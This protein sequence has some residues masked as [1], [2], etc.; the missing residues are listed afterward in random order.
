MS[1]AS[2]TST[3]ITSNA[4]QKLDILAV[5][6]EQMGLNSTQNFCEAPVDDTLDKLSSLD[7]GLNSSDLDVNLSGITLDSFSETAGLN[8][9]GFGD[10]KIIEERMQFQDRGSCA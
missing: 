6:S 2:V 4:H 3:V 7:L 5:A 9:L 8:C 1:E 10:G